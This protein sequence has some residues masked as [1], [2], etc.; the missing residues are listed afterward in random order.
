[1]LVASLVA[2]T[3][4][5]QACPQPLSPGGPP[6]CAAANVPGC[7]PGYHREV[8]AYGR[9]R[10]ACDAGPYPQP[11]G[12]PEGAFL[13]APPPRYA[14]GPP[15]AG[16]RQS[17]LWSASGGRRGVVGLVLMPG[18]SSTP[19]DGH[20]GTSAGGVALEL[21]PDYGGGRLRLSIDGTR[22]ARAV[23]AGLKYDFFDWSQVRP[24]LAMGLGSGSVDPDPN[25]RLTG[26]VAGGVDLYVTNNVFFTL[27]VKG[28][29]FAD[30]ASSAD[31]GLGTGILH[32]T[33]FF[34][35]LGL[36]F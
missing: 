33:T 2:A 28:R 26:S 14:P 35:G 17:A 4:L 24:F 34:M 32:E 15:P 7:L 30:R 25:W 1:M 36:Y 3:V 9:A 10:Y 8:D 16:A 11:S 31:Y 29:A 6:P 27:E 23:E 13:P 5:S 19:Y 22:Y 21:R 20:D 12:P 18:V